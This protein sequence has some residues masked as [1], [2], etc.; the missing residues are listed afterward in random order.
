MFGGA[1]GMDPRFGMGAPPSA[2]ESH[3][4]AYSMAMLNGAS[5][6]NVT[7]GGKSECQILRHESLQIME[8][9]KL[10]KEKVESSDS[11]R[12]ALPW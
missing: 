10:R 8:K 7:Y 6:D 4:K 2:Y 9:S 1:G 5:R 11:L 3:F 12:R